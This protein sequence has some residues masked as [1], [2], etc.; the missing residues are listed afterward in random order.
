MVARNSGSVRRVLWYVLMLVALL[1]LA[2]AGC[3]SRKSTSSSGETG[4]KRAPSEVEQSVGPGKTK[5]AEGVDA[6]AQRLVRQLH[7]YLLGVSSE[8][9]APADLDEARAKLREMYQFNWPQKDPW[10][11]GYVYRQTGPS[12]FEVF[13]LGPDG[14]EGT[15]DDIF[16]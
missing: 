10:G 5:E 3:D 8:H 4:G 13:S 7:N 15:A 2:A 1:V 12:T 6:K 9:G 11:N 14:I 16:P